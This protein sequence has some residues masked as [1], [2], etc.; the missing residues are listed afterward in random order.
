MEVV[1]STEAHMVHRD[2]LP[3]GEVPALEQLLLDAAE[4]LLVG[5]EA[6]SQRSD[7]RWCAGRGQGRAVFYGAGRQGSKVRLLAGRGEGWRDV[8]ELRQAA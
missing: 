2:E 3:G 6:L 1:E 5:A 7:L 8:G 4:L